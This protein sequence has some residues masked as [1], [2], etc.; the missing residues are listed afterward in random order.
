MPAMET[1]GQMANLRKLN[2]ASSVGGSMDHRR[3]VFDMLGGTGG[4]QGVY[5][6]SVGLSR[7]SQAVEVPQPS[8]PFRK[9]RL[10]GSNKPTR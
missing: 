10:F 8:G 6:S 3:S 7:H 5:E 1:G 9:T 2:D 4:G